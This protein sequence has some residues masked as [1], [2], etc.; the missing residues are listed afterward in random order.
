MDSLSSAIRFFKFPSVI[1]LQECKTGN[2]N[3]KTFSKPR[4]WE[5]GGGLITAVHED[6]TALQVSDTDFEILTL[7]V[8]LGRETIRVLNAYCPQEP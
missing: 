8:S 3:V 6:F 2:Q 4:K 7:E 1:T 5:S